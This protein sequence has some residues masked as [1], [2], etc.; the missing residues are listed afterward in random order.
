MHLLEEF[1]DPRCRPHFC[2]NIK[3]DGNKIGNRDGVTEEFD[4]LTWADLFGSGT[5]SCRKLG[6]NQQY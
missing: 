5:F 4:N 1:Y 2:S 3:K 6:N